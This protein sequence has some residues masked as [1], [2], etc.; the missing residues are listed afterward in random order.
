M[1]RVIKEILMPKVGNND[2]ELC[3]IATDSIDFLDYVQIRLCA[4]A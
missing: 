4:L 1:G 2:P 3:S